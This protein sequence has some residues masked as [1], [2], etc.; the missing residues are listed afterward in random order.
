[1]IGRAT[2]GLESGPARLLTRCWG[3][4]SIDVRQKWRALWPYLTHLPV[5]GVVVVDAGCGAGRWSLELAARR[6]GWHVFGVDQSAKLVTQ[7]DAARRTLG[8]E[9][10][11]FVSQDFSCY[12]P[13]EPVDVVLSVASVHY[14]VAAG[15]GAEV[16]RQLASWLKPGGILLLWAPRSQAEVP[17]VRWLPPPFRLRDVIALGA[18]P[19]LLAG[20]ELNIESLEAEVGLFGTVAKQL[21]RTF[22]RHPVIRLA[23]YPLQIALDVADRLRGNHAGDGRSSA[24]VLVARRSARSASRSRTPGCSRLPVSG[25]RIGGEIEASPSECDA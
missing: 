6:P 15:R 22:A 14:Q 2:A 8:L 11:T 9:N 7:A 5:E 21:R 3:L 4:A 12:R 1:M 24:L 20:T 16:F 23:S 25:G 10:A 18:L 17:H 13:R 19:G